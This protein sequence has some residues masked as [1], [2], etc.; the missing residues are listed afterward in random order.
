MG[1]GA[2]VNK[3]LVVISGTKVR[4]ALDTTTALEE[5][6]GLRKKAPLIVMAA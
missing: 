1:G 5:L 6:H 3:I 4:I 2:A